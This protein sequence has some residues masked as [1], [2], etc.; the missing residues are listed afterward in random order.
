MNYPKAAP[1]GMSNRV[2]A[3]IRRVGRKPAR[4]DHASILAQDSVVDGMG[5]S[6]HSRI[7]PWR[8]AGRLPYA[9]CSRKS[10]R[11]SRHATVEIGAVAIPSALPEA[12]PGH[13]EARLAHQRASRGRTQA[14]RA[15]SATALHG[16]RRALLHV[17][18]LHA[19]E[20]REARRRPK[21]ACRRPAS[22]H[23]CA[24]QRHAGRQK[25]QS[26]AGWAGPSRRIDGG[27]GQNRTA[28]T[29]IFSRDFGAV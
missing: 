5:L 13:D 2:Y 24:S 12:H 6:Q 15:T 14:R 25:Q 23:G 9:G 26:P 11:G 29:R 16:G 8:R 28:D 7:C 27:Q 20:S 1:C 10:A 21:T 17:E 4:G 19:M 18:L 3:E 22:A